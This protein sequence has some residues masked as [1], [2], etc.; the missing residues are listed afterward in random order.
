MPPSDLHL[1]NVGLGSTKSLDPVESSKEDLIG[2]VLLLSSFPNLVL[3]FG[4]LSVVIRERGPV[5][6]CVSE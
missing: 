3:R 5:F 6:C 2:S 4:G 1:L